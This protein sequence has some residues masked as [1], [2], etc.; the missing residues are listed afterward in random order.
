MGVAR[1]ARRPAARRWRPRRRTPR[2]GRRTPC[3]AAR[4]ETSL[5]EGEGRLVSPAASSAP[6]H[7]GGDGGR[8]AYPTPSSEEW[9]RCPWGTTS[10]AWQS[11]RDYPGVGAPPVGI[12]STPVRGGVRGPGQFTAPAPTRAPRAQTANELFGLRAL[13]AP[14]KPSILTA[15]KIT[16]TFSDKKKLKRQ[17]RMIT[18]MR[19]Y[20]PRLWWHSST[21]Q[22]G[23]MSWRWSIR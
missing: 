16:A 10:A 12:G 6:N 23:S 17:A 2:P 4:Q 22:Q 13:I 7:G 8:L 3:A 11:G 21:F 15:N 5:V 14:L 20:P 19:W 18:A 9:G 1:R